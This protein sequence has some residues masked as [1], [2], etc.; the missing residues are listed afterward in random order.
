MNTL[1]GVLLNAFL[2]TTPTGYQTAG[3]KFSIGGARGTQLYYNI[4]GISANSPAFGVQNS[5]AEPSVESIAEMKF[6]AVNNKAEFGEVTNVTAIT[7]SGQNE[8]H[9]RL[10]EQNTTSV[11]T[12]RPFFAASRGQNIINDFGGS[13][14]GPINGCCR[15]L[16]RAAGPGSAWRSARCSSA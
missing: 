12:A 5:P 10:F 11:L 6:N 16:A 15:R 3:S 1:N 13:V 7:K 8:F 9:G 14:G 4:D 2:F